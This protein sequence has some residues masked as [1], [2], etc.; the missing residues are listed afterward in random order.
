[1]YWGC[2]CAEHH[3]AT[4]RGRH[5]LGLTREACVHGRCSVAM[6]SAGGGIAAPPGQ[7]STHH[8]LHRA[9]TCTAARTTGVATSTRWHTAVVVAAG[10]R[11]ACRV[12]AA[13]AV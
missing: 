5:R 9:T 4:R 13:V 7:A 3:N 11:G 6:A 8:I 1:M 2:I 10:A 12:V